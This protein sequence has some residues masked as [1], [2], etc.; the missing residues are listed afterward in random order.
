DRPQIEKPAIPRSL[1]GKYMQGRK[2]RNGE[3]KEEED[4]RHCPF[5]HI[6]KR[7]A[8]E[9]GAPSPFL[10]PEQDDPTAVI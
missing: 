3:E 5:M 6:K 10:K 2:S 1:D 9:C 8:V 4:C 7:G